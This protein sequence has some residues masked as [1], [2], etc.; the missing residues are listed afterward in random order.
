[1][2]V[3]LR[4]SKM[5]RMMRRQSMWIHV[6]AVAAA[7]GTAA[8]C[9]GGGDK[10]VVFC[11]PGETQLCQCAPDV[12]GVQACK[13]DGSGFEPCQCETGDADAGSAAD[14]AQVCKPGSAVSCSCPAGGTGFQKCNA[15]GTGYLPC[16]CGVD[17]GPTPD[18]GPSCA[19]HAEQKCSDGAVYWFDDCGV[20]EELVQECGPG[21][22]CE[23]AAC[24]P[25]APECASHASKACSQGAVYWFDS[26]GQ[27][28]SLAE[29]CAAGTHCEG[30][31]C[32]P[33]APSC[34]PHATQK[35]DGDNVYWFNSCDEKESVAE[36]CDPTQFCVESHCVKANFEG[37]WTVTAD[38]P[39][40]SACGLGS[41]QFAPMD[42]VL[43]V[44]DSPPG[45]VEAHTTVLGQ[46]IDYTGTLDGKK[47]TLQASYQTTGAL[48]ASVYHDETWDVTF[49]AMNHFEGI[50]A[51]SF[52]DDS[53]LVS[54]TLYWNVLGDRKQ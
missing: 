37:T 20:R 42:L 23:G 39:T 15:D 50:L 54:C 2:T 6:V 19:S 41:A 33:D 48:G 4:S 43:T 44:L 9:S 16:Y 8:G 24:V 52:H 12:T 29:T 25:D 18:V 28:E 1:M 3:R 27:P 36:I 34:T 10:Q 40:K 13:D 22:H 31:E 38:P 35:C 26:C 49:T 51:D 47:L 14:V 53:G 45:A 46:T 21:M 32:V 5:G 11:V 30:G 7:L 17:A